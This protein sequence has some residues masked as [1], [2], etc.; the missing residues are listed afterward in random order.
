M[1]T[2]GHVVAWTIPNAHAL[3]KN[4]PGAVKMH[5]N[6]SKCCYTFYL[7]EKCNDIG[8]IPLR[9]MATQSRLA[10]LH[11]TFLAPLEQV[12]MVGWSWSGDFSV[13]AVL[14]HL[15]FFCL[16]L[17]GTNAENATAGHVGGLA[18][19]YF[20]VARGGHRWVEAFRYIVGGYLPVRDRRWQ[21]LS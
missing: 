18:L 1:A 15:G 16:R 14:G 11:T 12:T 2:R 5:T 3:L 13:S 6:C 20:W 21:A 17:C 7:L 10:H 4:H 8:E 19:G 9:A